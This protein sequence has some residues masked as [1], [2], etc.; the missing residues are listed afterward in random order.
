MNRLRYVYAV[1]RPF[2]AALPE[3]LR[4]VAGA[5]AYPLGH[6]G[7]TA[8][9]SDVPA[10][11]FGEAPLRKRLEDLDWLAETAR[12]H[13]A[14]V[15]A[16]ASVGS[17]LPLRLATVCHDDDGVRRLLDAG[18]SRFVRTLERLDGR[19]EWGVKVYAE[20]AAAGPA[21]AGRGGPETG[22][23]YLRRRLR[24][25]RTRESSWQSADGVARRLHE[26][27]SRSAEGVR[28]HPPQRAELSGAAGENI[29]N[30]A[31]LV[32]R[33]ESA[34]FVE[35]VRRLTP[36]EP[37]VRMELTGPW[38]PYSFATGEESEEPRSDGPDRDGPAD[39][40]GAGS[41]GVARGPDTAPAPGEAL[42]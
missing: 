10:E 18:R 22:Q 30:A 12:A 15:A 35:T 24:E 16:V 1:T 27:L 20:K 31:F 17:P 21:P 28:L 2:G 11:D 23:D 6:D 34:A 41:G 40:R 25:R 7:L 42:R 33:E 29:L 9:V 8:V 3:E 38:A 36:G 32:P 37:G 13:E 4:G 39:G 14:V 26:E 19:V 5:P